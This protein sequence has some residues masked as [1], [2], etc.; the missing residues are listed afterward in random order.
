MA[1]YDASYTNMADGSILAEASFI[2]GIK[3][4]VGE[5]LIYEEG[6]TELTSDEKLED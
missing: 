3:F 4:E 1:S 5:A 2:F 6:G